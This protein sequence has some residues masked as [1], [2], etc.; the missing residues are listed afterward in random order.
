MYE[1]NVAIDHDGKLVL[2]TIGDD[3]LIIKQDA[4]ILEVKLNDEQINQVKK[5]IEENEFWKLPRD[6]STPSEDGGFGYITV[7]LSDKTRSEEH[8]LNSS[9]VAISYAVFCLKKKNT[10]T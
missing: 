1:E 8:R 10:D 6:V 4:P 9:H 3:D 7:N 5:V 2:Y